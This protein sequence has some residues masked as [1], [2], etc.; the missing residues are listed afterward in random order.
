MSWISFAASDAESRLRVQRRSNER[1]PAWRARLRKQSVECSQLACA[2]VVIAVASV[3]LAAA[4]LVVVV[5]TASA[6]GTARVLFREGPVHVVHA[7]ILCEGER[8]TFYVELR[9]PNTGTRSWK[10]V[11]VVGPYAQITGGGRIPRVGGHARAWR[12]RLEG[13]LTLRERR[14]ATRGDHDQGPT[15]RWVRAHSAATRAPPAGLRYAEQCVV[16]IGL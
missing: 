11:P 9:F 6:Y 2:T 15:G 5:G 10:V 7:R 1:L 4:A 8:G 14:E 12:A 16:W 13:F 3:A